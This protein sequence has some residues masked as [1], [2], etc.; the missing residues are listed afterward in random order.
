MLVRCDH[1]DAVSQPARVLISH[2]IAGAAVDDHRMRQMIGMDMLGEAL[3]VQRRSIM[4][5]RAGT[6]ILIQFV[7]CQRH[8]AGVRQR[9]QSQ[10]DTRLM[11]QASS[12]PIDLAKQCPP[13]LTGTDQADRNGLVGQPECRMHG[14][15]CARRLGTVDRN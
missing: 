15:Q 4:G 7:Q 5:K 2:G 11:Q 14:A 6:S 1:V 10:I 8:P 3:Q 13:D 9:P 12:G